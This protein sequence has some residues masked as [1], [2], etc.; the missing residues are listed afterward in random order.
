VE[1]FRQLV[2]WLE[3]LA[4]PTQFLLTARQTV[5]TMTAITQIDLDELAQCAA[6]E[7]VQFVAEEKSIS[8]FDPQVVYNL[9]GGN[10]LA[11][12]LLV[13]QMQVLPPEQVLACM[14]IGSID[15]L[16]TYIY[17]QSWRALDETAQNLLFTM[18]RAG[19]QA[20]WAW[21]AM[22]ND[23]N[24]AALA[25]AL[26]S[27]F[28]LSLVQPQRHPT[29]EAGAPGQRTYAIHRLTSTFLRTEVLGWK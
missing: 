25:A 5:P 8:G 11:I 3:H 7:L 6:I 26:Q 12:I 20:D 14:R 24:E 22:T 1:D 18:Q 21:L 4:G 29:S 17:W 28:D 19:D 27:L 9:V 13:S 2:P 16:Y 23:L 15:S 10:P